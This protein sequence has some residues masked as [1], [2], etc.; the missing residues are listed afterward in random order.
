MID[1]KGKARLRMSIE[2]GTLEAYRVRARNTNVNDV[3]LLATDYL[4]H[5]NEALMLAELVMDMPD[6]LD[7]FIGWGPCSYK[8]HFAASGIAD[9]EL[10]I[11]AYAFS[12]TEYKQPFETTIRRLDTEIRSLQSCL[13]TSEGLDGVQNVRAAAEHQCQIIR[14]LI[15]NAGAIING[16]LREAHMQSFS[17]STETG[18]ANLDQDEINALFG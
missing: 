13:G 7:E 8:D 3:T 18:E 14:E 11:E 10:A 12:P 4:N 16:K 15:D 5:F 2:T 17:M 9:K 1:P 6:M